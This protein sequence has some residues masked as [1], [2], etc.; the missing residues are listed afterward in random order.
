MRRTTIIALALALAAGGAAA[1]QGLSGEQQRL[2]AAR[3][4][5]S[6]AARRA[7]ALTRA[8]S[9]EANAADRAQAEEQA[10]AARVDAAA[11]DLTAAQARVALVD[12][13]IAAQRRRLAKQQAPAARLLGALVSLARRPA[14]AS[15]VQLGSVADQVHVR[16]VLA[17]T[18]P[19][20]RARTADLRAELTRARRLQAASA[21][22]TRALRDGRARLENERAEFAALEARH[23]A[24]AGA[25]GRS[26]LGE[27]DRALALGERARDLVDRLSDEGRA[28]ATSADLAG[29]TGP[30]PRPLAPGTVLP[31]TAAG[32]YRLPVAGRLVTGFGEISSAGVRSRGLSFVVA[33]GA[34]VVAPAAGVVRYAG[35]FRGYGIIVILDHGDGWSSLLTGLAAARVAVGERVATGGAIGT[36][37]TGDDPRITVELRRRGEPIDAAALVG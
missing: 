16:A 37:A 29:L 4:A 3:A 26:A 28:G 10:V 31:A 19:V 32:V 30:L 24:K 21:L 12:T 23:R 17:S 9:G 35:R 27:S 1:A 7:K 14:V 13:L 33:P 2:V 15:L 22:A 20:V 36:A 8:A 11:A 34:P 25:L 5:A 6:A 18:L